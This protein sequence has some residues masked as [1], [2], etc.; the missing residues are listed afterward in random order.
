M[1]Q[2]I[3]N[4]FKLN[5]TILGEG[6]D[7]AFEYLKHLLD[8]KIYEFKTGET[9]GTWT[10]PQEWIVKDAW[11]KHKGKKII[12]YQKQPLSLMVY[13]EPFKGI[14]DKDE[15][16]KHL[17]ISD[18]KPQA[19]PYEYSFYKKQWGFSVPKDFV[20]KKA[21]V[22]LDC[23]NDLRD[24]DPA[25][26]KVR[27][28]GITDKE[29]V[30]D[31]LKNGKYEVFIDTEFRDGIMKVAEYTI[32]GE[33]DREII[34]I[35]HL[36]HPFQANDNLSAVA[37]LVDLAKK[38]KCKHTVKIVLCPETIGSAAYALSRD[39][40]KTDFVISVECIGNK[41]SV[42]LQKSW[43]ADCRINKVA[44]LAVSNS[45]E[46]Y[47][48]GNFRSLLGGDE[49]VFNDPNLNIP[50]I[51]LSRF[52]FDE[53]HTSA[54]TPDKIDYENI[55]KI[56]KIILKIIDIYEKDY[57]PVK[58]F[59]GTLF[60]EKFGVQTFEKKLNLAMDY[61][62]YAIDGKTPLSLIVS[63]C[64]LN[65]DYCYS[66]LEELKKSDHISVNNCETK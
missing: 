41:N 61:F 17:F 42:L 5:R 3:E 22:C 30:I 1:K 13:A 52:P 20:Y 47:R 2:I 62:I 15:L 14:I 38:I 11:V 36:D 54:D 32:K 12:D 60:R 29:T 48:K 25:V 26:G 50:G 58:V 40:S 34:L 46:D 33:S 24:I 9:Y 66:L 21:N 51:L 49:Y 55:E 59:D 37:C 39:L 18:E 65:F 63:D 23:T 44:H 45:G 53:Y 8:F 31:N 57:I 43:K 56:Q 28:D 19:I 4:L 35:A 27:I 7:N 10:I 6:I 16:K 64:G